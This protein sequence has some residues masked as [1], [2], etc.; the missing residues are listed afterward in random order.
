MG[1]TVAPMQP[2]QQHWVEPMLRGCGKVFSEEEIRMALALLEQAL[3]GPYCILAALEDERLA[4]CCLAGPTPLTESTWHLYWL[5]VHPDFQRQRVASALQSALED[6]VRAL[7]G[8]RIVVETAS[9]ADYDPARAFYRSTGY[10]ERGRIADYYRP[11]DA[12]VF[13]CK[14]LR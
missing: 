5:C 3:C 6:N 2:S 9:R 7:G 1:M 13:F 12:C 4:G 11:G 8:R 10:D 14:V